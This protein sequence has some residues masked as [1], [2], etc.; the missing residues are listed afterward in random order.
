MQN[1]LNYLFADAEALYADARY[2]MLGGPFDG[3]TSYRPGTR[4]GPRAIR[5][6]SY[7]FEPY[8]PVYDL[9]LDQVPICD[10]G[11]LDLPVVSEE[12]VAMVAEAIADLIRDR[13]IPIFFGGE[14]T[15]TVGAVRAV[16]PDW[17]VV[18]DA[19]LDLREEYRGAVYNHGCTSRLVYNEGTTNIVMI[20]QRSGTREQYEFAKELILYS[21]DQVRR[22]GIGVVLDEVQ[23]TIG[24]QGVYLSIDADAIDCC[25]TPG[26]GTPEPFGLTPY[27]L[28]E[29]VTRLAPQ[30]VGFDYVE[31]CPTDD[32]QTAAVATELIRLFIAAHW[33]A[34]RAGTD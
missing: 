22:D 30:A 25:Y 33:S 16:K 12:A 14:H 34:R 31:V 2:C 28:R 4:F 29:V 7:N 17:F 32:G 10:L 26:L 9:D 1:V 11:D 5:D 23:Q 3:T 15:L 8:I 19:H 27:D 20:G 13:K 18:C 21:S 24:D 6:V